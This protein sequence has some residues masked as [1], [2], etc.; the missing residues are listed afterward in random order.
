MPLGASSEVARETTNDGSGPVDTTP[1]LEN[2]T[3]W[4]QV[5]DQD[6]KSV[7]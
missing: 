3:L 2:R 1:L 7:V 5:A 6:R 4:E